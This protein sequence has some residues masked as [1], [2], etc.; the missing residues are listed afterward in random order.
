MKKNYNDY[1]RRQPNHSPAIF[2]MDDL[3]YSSDEEL[4]SLAGRLESERSQLLSRGLDPYQWEVEISYVRRE[5]QLRKLRA[6]RHADWLAS[7]AH[8]F[9]DSESHNL[10]EGSKQQSIN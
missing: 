2:N 7:T 9:Q 5:Q 1:D 6:E 10:G 3:G 8:H 4:F